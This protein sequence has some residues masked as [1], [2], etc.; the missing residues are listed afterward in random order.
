MLVDEA[1]TA[2]ELSLLWSLGPG[3]VKFGN[4]FIHSEELAWVGTQ[5]GG[6]RM[7]IYTGAEEFSFRVDQ[8]G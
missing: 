6:G 1:N 7:Q 3:V 5:E 2:F 8:F 4:H